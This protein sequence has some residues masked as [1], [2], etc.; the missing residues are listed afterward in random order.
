MNRAC[1]G[2]AGLVDIISNVHETVIHYPRGG[3]YLAGSRIE[4][5][6]R[7][8]NLWIPAKDTGIDLLVTDRANRKAV[9]LQVK[10][11]KDFLVAH[12]QR[13]APEFQRKLRACGWW[14]LNDKK[15]RQSRSDYWVFVLLGFANTSRDYIVIPPQEL[16]RRLRSI[17]HKRQPK[18]WQVYLW[19]TKTNFC[20]E[21]RGLKKRDKL[22]ITEGK[23][24]D[25]NRDFTKYLNAWG[26]VARLN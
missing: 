20:V 5:K 14:T 19:V 1:I 22:L 17:H 26:C 12:M 18:I 9:S 25:S 23:F 21:T 16:L 4:E 7:H 8:V 11:S 3:E 15:L 2:Y 6:F 13:Q 10:F 24:S